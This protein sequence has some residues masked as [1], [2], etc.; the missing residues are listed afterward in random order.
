MYRW[1]ITRE[2]NI[3]LISLCYKVEWQL[4]K[5]WSCS[6]AKLVYSGARSNTVLLSEAARRT[7]WRKF[8]LTTGTTI[9]ERSIW[10]AASPANLYTTTVSCLIHTLNF[11][12]TAIYGSDILCTV[13]FGPIFYQRL[14]HMVLDKMHAR[15]RGP[16]AVLTRQPTEGRSRD[17]GLRLGEME[18][19]CLVSHGVSA[20]LLERLMTS[21][22]AFQCDICSSCGMIVSRRETLTVCKSV[23]LNSDPVG[24]QFMVSKVCQGRLEFFN[25]CAECILTYRCKSAKDMCHITLPYAAKLLT[26]GET[27]Y[28]VANLRSETDKYLFVCYRACTYPLH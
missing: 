19:D 25:V 22:D 1:I 20:V 24:L 21:S 13:F 3:K 10:Q 16:R 5:C 12:F 11:R 28:A 8:W 14:K 27:G 26:Q 17:G 23:W 2:C 6:V 18:R 9:L 15:A 4:A 7:T